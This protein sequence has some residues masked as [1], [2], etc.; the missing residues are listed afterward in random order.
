MS[1]DGSP[2]SRRAFV[3]VVAGGVATVLAACRQRT[4][5]G[6]VPTDSIEPGEPAPDDG[7]DPVTV[8]PDD[9]GVVMIGDSLTEGAMVALASAF[10]AGNI[11][12]QRIDGVASRRIAVD[13]DGGAVSGVTALTAAVDDGL[14]P[15]VWVIALG[16]NDV[17]KYAATEFAALIAQLLE[18]L[19]TDGAGVV[20]VNTYLRDAAGQASAFNGALT[21]IVGERPFAVVADWAGEAPTD[22]LLIGDG[23]HFTDAGNAAFASLVVAAVDQLR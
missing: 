5:V 9:G 16:T 21:A 3:A 22:G 4:E 14:A 20:W 15:D 7:A 6:G 1:R 11:G 10:A 18:A 23:I 13:Q 2:L 12:V 8:A 19:P 17:T